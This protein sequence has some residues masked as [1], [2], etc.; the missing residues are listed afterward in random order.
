MSSVGQKGCLLN[1]C[2]HCPVLQLCLHC[3]SSALCFLRC[4]LSA[5]WSCFGLIVRQLDPVLL[6]RLLHLSLQSCHSTSAHRPVGFTMAPRSFCSNWERR[7]YIS[8]ELLLPSGSDS[9]SR[10][11]T[12]AMDLQTFVRASF[13]H[14]FG[15]IRL[16]IPLAPPQSS[17]TPTLPQS[18]GTQFFLG[19]SSPQLCL[20]LQDL[21]CHSVSSTLPESLPPSVSRLVLSVLSM[22]PPSLSSTVGLRAGIHAGGSA[23]AHP[24]ANSSLA[25][26]ALSP[27]WLFMLSALPWL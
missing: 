13:F 10:H 14:L 8:T 19:C 16:R 24:I 7:P 9:V 21:L 17:G 22:A 6:T 12:M 1:P 25:S 27:P 18:S 15:S 23:L 4:L 5:L 3:L 11:S 2:L 26:A 20:G